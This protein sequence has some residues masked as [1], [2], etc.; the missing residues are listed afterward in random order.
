MSTPQRENTQEASE[1]TPQNPT[2]AH[3]LESPAASDDEGVQ[4][5]KPRAVV[6]SR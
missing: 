1:F 3:V 4:G 2:K 5:A 6:E